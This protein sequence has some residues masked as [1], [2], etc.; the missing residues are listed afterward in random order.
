MSELTS[1]PLWDHKTLTRSLSG[2]EKR[3]SE[4]EGSPASRALVSRASRLTA[5]SSQAGE[6]RKK[7]HLDESP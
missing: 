2:E 7:C 4:E 6:R 3:V 1:S 5:E